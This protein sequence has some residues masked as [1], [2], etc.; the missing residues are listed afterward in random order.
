MTKKSTAPTYLSKNQLDVETIQTR[1]FG[2]KPLVIALTL[3]TVINP[4]MTLAASI[5]LAQEP[6]GNGGREPA[7]NLIISVD[8]SG[9]MR[10]T[11]AGGGLSRIAA[12]RNAL[13]SSFSA[14]AI[15]DNTIRLGFQAMWRCL[16]FGSD[17]SNSY[18]GACPENR[19]RPFSGD[20]R[21]GFNNWVNSLVDYGWTPSHLV[22]KKAGEFMKTT[23]SW[24]PYAKIPGS[25]ETPLLSCRKSFHIFMTDG[26]WNNT[27][28]SGARTP[29]TS[30]Y[31]NAD[32]TSVTLPDGTLYDT[33][34][35]NTQTRAYRDAFGGG[36]EYNTFSDLAF[37][38]WATD[39][40]PDIANNIRPI[41]RQPNS[42]D[43]GTTGSPYL[44][45]EYWNPKNDP[46]TWQHLTTYTIGFGGGATLSNTTDPKWGG[47]SWVGTGYT[48][49]LKGNVG[50][51]YPGEPDWY[52]DAKRKDLWHAALNG[53]GRYIPATNAT[54]LSN[55]FAE[56]IN[57][58]I[59]DTSTPLASIAANTQ[60]FSTGTHVYLAGYDATRWSGYVKAKTVSRTTGVSA[61]DMWDAATELDKPAVT[62]SSRFILTHNGTVGKTF[63]WGNL[64]ATQK[65]ALQGTDTATIAQERLD[66]L[67]GDRTKEQS[68]GGTHRNRNSRLGD[69]V[70]S[71]LWTVGK[72]ELGY[73]VNDY[74][75]FRS[76]NASRSTMV[77]VGANDGMLHGF[78]AADGTEK[79][80][81]VPLGV[82]DKLKAY[83]DPAYVHHYTVDG[84]PYT[85]DIFDGSNWKTMLIGS[86][87]GGGKGYFVLDVTNPSDFS[88]TNP[89]PGDLVVTDKTS[90]S[91]ADIGHIHAEPVLDTSNRARAVQMTK[92]NNG[93]WAV[94]MGNGVN[95]SSEK[96]VLLIQ[97]LD[98]AKELVKMELD[99]T[100]AN[101]NGLSNPQVIDI[102]GDGKADVAYAGDLLGNLWKIDLSSST[103]SD[104][105]SY[106]KT[107][108]VPKPLFVARD[109]SNAGQPITTAPQWGTHPIKGLMLAFGTGR[110]MTVADRTS[111]SDQT[112][113]SIWDDTVFS[114]KATPMMSG[115]SAIPDLNAR[116]KLVAQSQSGTA[117]T[118]GGEKYFKTTTNA[119]IYT[120][121]TPKRGWYMEWPGQGERSVNNGGKLTNA[122]MYM[123]SRIPANGSQGS[124]TEESCVPNATAAKEYLTILDMVYGKPPTKPTFD[125]DASG[126]V[127]SS[128]EAGV[129]RWESG[130]EDRLLM[131]GSKPGELMSISGEP[132]GTGTT[133]KV[134]DISGNAFL[135]GIGW[136]QLQ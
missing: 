88:A 63:T 55:A 124:S 98:G 130:K 31:G 42:I 68:A 34:A 10:A 66:Y 86:L 93:R 46:A 136:R 105:G 114:P 78:S 70:N 116:D 22:Q 33:S 1:A 119:V 17:L 35:A 83:T 47:S 48:N 121:A 112:L 8:D 54:E 126:S 79:L 30:G 45:N 107:G 28:G 27:N 87:A 102:N 91:D 3:A 24:N 104:W 73:A 127:N 75:T 108:S 81:Y 23:G 32:G 76:N 7:P 21:T 11:D 64:N 37:Y 16:G 72:P 26:E 82:Y 2:F 38:Y 129:S 99:S 135:T 20:H 60:S 19:V 61:A 84:H 122:L 40:Q 12:L 133:K 6:A 59:A 128:D 111:S 115:G 85:G 125:T 39:L 50:W 95:S 57:Q 5:T 41:I 67:R 13:N 65:D 92:L 110:E 100:S 9:S 80:A 4:S 62:A 44:I 96:A 74:R 134:Q 123:R 94:L 131:G 25:Q 58:I 52:N 51:G 69:I 43:I 71:N 89:S 117:L 90:G 14:T 101:G 120:G 53:R 103:A 106:F 97:Y 18:G 109:G 49:L 77:Y 118:L 29:G 56:I 15:P 132:T 36:A 113:Y